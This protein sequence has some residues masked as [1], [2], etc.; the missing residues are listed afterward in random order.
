MAPIE[1][2]AGGMIRVDLKDPKISKKKRTLSVKTPVKRGVKKVWMQ[3][4]DAADDT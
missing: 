4:R 2:S 1:A 3:R